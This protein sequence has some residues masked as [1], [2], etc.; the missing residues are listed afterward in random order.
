MQQVTGYVQSKEICDVLEVRT[1]VLGM[2]SEGLVAGGTAGVTERSSRASQSCFKYVNMC[3]CV[4]PQNQ[5][6]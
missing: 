3:V 6:Y 2:N 1:V 4:Y 5:T